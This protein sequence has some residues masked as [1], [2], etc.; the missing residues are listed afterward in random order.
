MAYDYGA[1]NDYQNAA[2]TFERVA[3]EEP[4]SAKAEVNLYNAGVFYVRAESWE[5]AIRVNRTFVSRYPNSKDAA[6]MFYEIAN[7]YL[8]LDDL[9]NA[10]KVYG[11]YAEKFP[12]SPR[13]VET[14]YRRGEYYSGKT[15][16]PRPRWNTKGHRQ[17]QIV[18]GT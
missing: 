9:D 16:R 4:D 6:N 8:K 2:L 14:F 15:I 10:N 18:S 12:D 11:E 17:E 13:T 7:F 3:N 5:R 1:M